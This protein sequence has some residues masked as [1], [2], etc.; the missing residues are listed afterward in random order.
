V[1]KVIVG[2]RLYVTKTYVFSVGKT[3]HFP[4]KKVMAIIIAL[5]GAQ[6]YEMIIVLLIVPAWNVSI[7]ICGCS[8]LWV[9]YCY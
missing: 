1:V 5:T 9:Y 2:E 8:E 4:V 6:L 3:I 7:V